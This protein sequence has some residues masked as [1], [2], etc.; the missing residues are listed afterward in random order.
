MVKKIAAR[1]INLTKGEELVISCDA[2]GYPLTEIKW[3]NRFGK[4]IGNDRIFRIKKVNENDEGV[5]T[6]TASNGISPSADKSIYI[7][8]FCK[9]NCF[10]LL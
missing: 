6:C 4:V 10:T 9:Y 5:Y 8:V 7:N 3:T 2:E 1:K